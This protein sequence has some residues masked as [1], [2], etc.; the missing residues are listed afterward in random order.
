MGAEPAWGLQSL[1]E[2]TA[3]LSLIVC[4]Y[5]CFLKWV[6]LF[7]MASITKLSELD[8]LEQFVP[9]QLLESSDQLKVL[10]G[11]SSLRTMRQTV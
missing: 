10:G 9:S 5:L 1:D 11:L 6:L 7:A 4:V 3:A 2:A 8:G